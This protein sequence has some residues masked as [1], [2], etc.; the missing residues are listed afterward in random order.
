MPEF[1][2]NLIG[3]S[4]SKE[5]EFYITFPDEYNRTDLRGKKAKFIVTIDNILEG[6]KLK[7][8]NE[9]AKKTGSKS[10]DDLRE[11]IKNELQKYS[12]DLSFNVLKKTIVNKLNS[13][14]SFSL[15]E[16]LVEREIEIINNQ[17]I[18]NNK[19]EKK[20]DKNIKKEAEDKVKIGLILSEI[21]IK[22]KI[23]VTEKELETALAKICMQYPGREKEI[24]EHYRKNPNYM[25]ALKGPIFEDKV[26][27]FVEEKAKI[28]EKLINSDELL[29]R[30]S[31][32]ENIKKN[33]KKG[34]NE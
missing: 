11:K 31:N 27:K 17:R 29:K 16:V 33:K 22:N 4:K 34:Q 30:V 23:N 7:D 5:I 3:K 21:G 8:E 2:N 6:K 32:N 12:E 18:T 20:E 15:P 9:L 26:I 1:E 14:Y 10:F 13:L 25:N 19:K 24:I 28:N